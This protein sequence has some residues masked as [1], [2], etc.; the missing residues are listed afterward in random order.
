MLGAMSDRED[1]DA[2]GRRLPSK[3]RRKKRAATA[4][5]HRWKNKW[6]LEPGVPLHWFERSLAG[7]LRHRAAVKKGGEATG[8]RVK[9]QQRLFWRWYYGDCKEHLSGPFQTV[10]ETFERIE[11]AYVQRYG[12]NG[13]K[14]M[15][16][17]GFFAVVFQTYVLVSCRSML[18]EV[19]ER[20]MWERYQVFM[21]ADDKALYG[22][23]KVPGL[24]QPLH[25]HDD[26]LQRKHERLA[27]WRAKQA[28]DRTN[29]K[30]K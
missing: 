29:R 26:S 7:E 8:R 4:A 24:L 21:E 3:Y 19:I 20:A 30:I 9:E 28:R 25:D 2:A 5:R 1:R 23:G 12:H 11:A 16:W 18:A 10:V 17:D 6:Q 22:D 15:A 27:L 13:P 14:A